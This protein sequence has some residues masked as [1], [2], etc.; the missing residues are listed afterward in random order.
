[1]RKRLLALLVTSS[2]VLSLLPTFL[3]PQTV[4]ADTGTTVATTTSGLGGGYECYQRKNFYANGRYWVFYSDGTDGYC[5]SSTDG[6]TWTSAQAIKTGIDRSTR[7]S[8]HFDGTYFHYV[9]AMEA[10]N[11]PLT[12]RMGTPGANGTITWAA[13]EQTIL[14][15]NATLEYRK[16]T[17]TTDGD[18]YPWVACDY[19]GGGNI[20]AYVLE[21]TTKDGTWTTAGDS[22]HDLLVDN[23]CKATSLIP[24]ASDDIYAFYV[25]ISKKLY[26]NKWNG[27]AWEGQE[28]VSVTAML[29]ES[30]YSAILNDHSNVIDVVWE[31]VSPYKTHFRERSLTG[32]WGDT[33]TLVEESAYIDPTLSLIDND[34]NLAL[35]Y[36]DIDGDNKVY[37]MY[38]IAGEWDESGT[39]WLDETTDTICGHGRL[40]S[41]AISNI[42]GGEC[43][44][45][46]QYMTKA[47]SPYNIKF[48][49]F[50]TPII[51]MTTLPASTVARTSARLNSI[52]DDDGA[53]DVVVK[54]GWGESSQP[55]IEAYD[56]YQTLE[57]TWNTGEHPYL[58][59]DSLSAS[60]TYYFRVQGITDIDTDLGSELTF[61]TTDVIDTPTGFKGVPGATSISLSW[62]LASGAS[63]YLVRY[64]FGSYPTTTTDGEQA[65]SGSSTST[66]HESLSAGATYYY[67]LWGESGGNYGN[68]T[69]LMLTTSASGG[70]AG[71]TLTP[72]PEP[73]NWMTGTDYTRMSGLGYFYD[74]VNGT[75]DRL[76]MPY[77]TLWFLLYMGLVGVL[78]LLLYLKIRQSRGAGTIVLA[79]LTILLFGGWIVGLVALWIPTLSTIAVIGLSISHKEVTH[80]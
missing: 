72:V 32:T 42:E 10:Y 74:G 76:D 13:A 79:L 49:L 50:G 47:S 16:P 19:V 54:F 25:D 67:A 38:R 62:D 9:T 69:T 5:K 18:G 45:G 71:G 52:V 24:V 37:Y 55:T 61:E 35:F 56:H 51:D 2:L 63:T 66:I 8:I 75:A 6:D 68:S 64:K 23:G 3:A 41:T 65:Y 22:P 17:V 7:F 20:H 57:G 33:E 58:D 78:T 29:A 12:Y 80:G 70:E 36:A 14:A 43:I 26:C 34:G 59:I 11:Q 46:L 48:V 44:V 21:S 1:M 30:Y 73:T 28:S 60:T 77:E 31:S 15:A 27:A 39:E 4:G 40:A 53:D